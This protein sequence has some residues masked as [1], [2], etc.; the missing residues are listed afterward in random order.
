MIGIGS[1]ETAN[2]VTHG[3]G[4]TELRWVLKETE[5]KMVPI[6]DNWDIRYS[7]RA[8]PEGTALESNVETKALD[9][10]PRHQ[11]GNLTRED[12]DPNPEHEL[13]G[14]SDRDVDCPRGKSAAKPQK[15]SIISDNNGTGIHGRQTGQKGLDMVRADAGPGACGVNGCKCAGILNHKCLVPLS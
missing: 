13:M 9:D 12:G 4:H 8:V 3:I 7:Q 6:F 10:S 5:S 1:F 11:E 14:N 15:G 2:G